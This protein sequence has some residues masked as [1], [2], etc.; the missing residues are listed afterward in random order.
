MPR[1]AR[2]QHAVEQV[3]AER[4]AADQI[5]RPPEP[6]EVARRVGGQLA[7]ADRDEL[8]ALCGGL[9]EPEPAVGEAAK[10]EVTGRARARAAQRR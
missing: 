4:D 7:V 6:H 10:A 1:V 9:A 3:D 5:G 2:R 8:V